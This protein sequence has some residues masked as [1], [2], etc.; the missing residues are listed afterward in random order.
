MP[1]RLGRA[2]RSTAAPSRTHRRS[3][4]PAGARSSWTTLFSPPPVADH[5]PT[6]AILFDSGLS[7]RSDALEHRQEVGQ[8]PCRI[9]R[10]G[11]VSDA[12]HLREGRPWD[13]LV[14]LPPHLD[15]RAVVVVT[16]EDVYPQRAPCRSRPRR[17]AG[18]IRP[19][20]TRDR[21]GM[22]AATRRHRPGSSPSDTRPARTA[23]SDP[24]SCEPSIRWKPGGARSRGAHPSRLRPS[25]LPPRRSP[26]GRRQGDDSQDRG[27]AVPQPNSP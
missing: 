14:G 15:R 21:R 5:R 22:P 23:R 18:R 3:V 26:P 19:G 4:P 11:E 12:K 16:G 20:S 9:L 7:G 24:P 10:H 13:R 6:A 1:G 8:E 17:S 25:A 2:S 27:R